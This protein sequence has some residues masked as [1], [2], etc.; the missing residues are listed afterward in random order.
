MAESKKVRCNYY[1]AISVLRRVA[2]PLDKKIATRLRGGVI[3]LSVSPEYTP[4]HVLH[5]TWSTQEMDYTSSAEP[6]IIR[7]TPKC[8]EWREEDC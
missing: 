8:H 3:H 6:P 5:K 2:A 4:R 1:V 7:V